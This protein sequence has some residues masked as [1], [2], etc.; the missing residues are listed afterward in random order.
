MAGAEGFLASYYVLF[1]SLIKRS[2][3]TMGVRE[4]GGHVE[5]KS[6]PNKTDT[7]ELAGSMCVSFFCF[8]NEH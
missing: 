1:P 7:V 6:W 2:R 4:R 3:V 5:T 8:N